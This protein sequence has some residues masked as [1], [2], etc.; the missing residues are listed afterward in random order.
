MIHGREFN[1]D[2][3]MCQRTNRCNE[4]KWLVKKLVISSVPAMK[5]G[6]STPLHWQIEQVHSELE[7]QLDFTQIGTLALN[8]T[9][10]GPDFN[11]LNGSYQIEA[12]HNPCRGLWTNWIVPFQIAY[13]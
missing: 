2:D 8:V 5:R 9:M 7:G 4:D 1:G 13:L 12:G 6:H 10:I 3:A 11:I